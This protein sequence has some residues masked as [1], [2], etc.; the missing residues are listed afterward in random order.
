MSADTQAKYQ[1]IERGRSA[2][3][4]DAELLELLKWSP[5]YATLTV[6]RHGA[7]RNAVSSST[8]DYE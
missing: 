3:L 4:T 7:E 6:N 5:P 8:E 2:I 1:A